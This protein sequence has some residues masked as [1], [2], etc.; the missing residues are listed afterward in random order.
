MGENSVSK[1]VGERRRG[2]LMCENN[3]DLVKGCKVL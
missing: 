2:K 1:K 3:K